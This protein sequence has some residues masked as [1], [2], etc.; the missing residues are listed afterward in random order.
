MPFA[1]GR[2]GERMGLTVGPAGAGET[3][4]ACRRP[5]AAA[6]VSSGCAWTTGSPCRTGTGC[7]PFSREVSRR[8]VAGWGW[9]TAF[10]APEGDPAGLFRST[11]IREGERT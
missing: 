10:S 1:L 2:Q 9:D 7:R 4:C 8:R 11:E 3:V 5:T 6:A